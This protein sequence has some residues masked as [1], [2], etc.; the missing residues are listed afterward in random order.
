MTADEIREQR[1]KYGEVADRGLMQIGDKDR[2]DFIG[3]MLQEIA[4]QLAEM[5]E[6]HRVRLTETFQG[7]IGAGIDAAEMKREASNDR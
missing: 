6:R 3:A 7:H 4:A 5:N 2:I 1:P